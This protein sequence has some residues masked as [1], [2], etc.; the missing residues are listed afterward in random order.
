MVYR[1]MSV[2]HDPRLAYWQQSLLESGGYAVV[3]AESAADATV[4]IHAGEVDAM[5]LGTGVTIE[6]RT[7][8]SLLGFTRNLPVICMCGLRG[9]NECPVVHVPPS[10][11]SELLRALD[12]VFGKVDSCRAQAA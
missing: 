4:K 5:F 7:S 3:N 1:V 8:L 6:D 2:S 11:P 10:Q 12:R 9:D